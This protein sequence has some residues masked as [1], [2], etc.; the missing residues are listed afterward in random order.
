VAD[1]LLARAEAWRAADPD[2]ETAAELALIISRGDMAEL[3]DRFAGRLE[4][5]TAGLRGLIGAGPNRMNRA[6]VRQT[7]EGLA[8]YL[9][10]HEPETRTRGVLVARDGRRKS[11]AFA[12]DTAG[13]L[14][15]HDIPVHFFPPPVPTP[16]CAFAT[17]RLS[18]AA[19]VMITA[20]HNPP[21]YNGY[22][23]Y[24]GNGGQI[25][26][27]HDKGIAAEI[28]AAPP[29]REIA[30]LGREEAR[31]RGL[32]REVGE[33]VGRAWIDAMLGER[34]HPGSGTDLCI[35]TTALHGVGGVWLTRALAEA[36]FDRV[37][38]VPEQQEPDGAFPTVKFPNPEEPG[39]MDL[40][41]AL[42]ERVKA[43][44]VL[45]N[46]PDAD[47]LAGGARDA[48]GAL[49]MLSGNE[50]GVLLGH[51]V[52]T[53]KN[54]RPPK[55]LVI[56]TIVS[57]AQLGHI[58]R[59]LGARYEETLTG[60]KWIGSRALELER[61]E[62]TT[63]LFGYEEALGYTVGRA[64]RDKDGVGSALVL[65][66]LAGWCRS[67]GQTLFDYLEAIQRKYGLFLAS[68][69]SFTFPGAEGRA[70]MNRLLAAFRERPPSR[71]G[72][73]AVVT[74]KDYARGVAT[75]GTGKESPRPLGLP[76]ANVLAF[77]LEGG[78]RVTLRPSGTE[79][80]LKYYFERREELQ[81]GESLAAAKA[82]GQE[83]LL[84]LAEAFLALARQGDEKR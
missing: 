76:A 28:E 75:T 66:D 69:K 15:A 21:D 4:F 44:V 42:A 68:S 5:G 55:P 27:P 83:R 47:R 6:V 31:S 80:K 10:A 9:L 22:K 16:L 20:S 46:D 72:D 33:E 74:I 13:V 19:A 82:R 1:D 77:E 71:V 63:F 23:V 25:I 56:T 24:W 26:P 45:A 18:A 79:P 39:A 53:E 35:V 78:A 57:S 29:A 54:P 40:A 32:L 36:G 51:Y 50:L 61:L 84:H 37:H 11:D 17:L 3:R 52:L 70:L 43:D 62:G 59:A 48:T 12:E 58:A 81:P 67:N 64:V 41:L 65:A 8:R 2:P 73:L 7:T 38:P 34:L 30:V 49:R 60:F 14:A